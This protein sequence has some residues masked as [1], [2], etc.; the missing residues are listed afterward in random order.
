MKKFLLFAFLLMSGIA[1]AQAIIVPDANFMNKLLTADVTNNIAKDSSGDPIK[2]DADSNGVITEAEAG[3]VYELDISNGG[4]SSLEGIQYFF[5]LWVLD[6][7]KNALG[8]LDVTFLTDLRRLKCTQNNMTILVVN[9]LSH[10]EVLNC[11][12]NHLTTLDL[13]GL[14]SLKDLNFYLNGIAT[15][16]FSETEYLEYLN[17]DANNIAALDVSGLLHL[18]SLNCSNN[19]LTTLDLNNNVNLTELTC[20]SNYLTTLFIKNG[21][22]ETFDAANWLENPELEYICADASQVAALQANQ[23]LSGVQIDSS[24]SG[25][26]AL[27]AGD[28]VME[29]SIKVYPNPAQDIVKITADAEI[30]SVT[31]YDIQGR[32]LQTSLIGQSEA[33]LDIAKRAA[34]IYIL[35][36]TTDKGT[37]VQKL[38]KQ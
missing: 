20:F 13:S 25:G 34:G 2:I 3:I 28:F 8:I 10:L 19:Q 4:I 21:Q 23:E 7:S 11:G 26:P 22:N 5:N 18:I 12:I 6:C 14:S 32:L 38:I 27:S 36:V 1:G 29:N 24:C 37:R 15:F 30:K 35:K 9:G 31:L 17:C 16:D 33:S